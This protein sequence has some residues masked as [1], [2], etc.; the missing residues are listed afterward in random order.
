MPPLQPPHSPPP[1]PPTEPQQPQ[2]DP[3]L[4]PA[5]LPED[6]NHLKRVCEKWNAINLESCDGCEREW[7][8]LNV[9]PTG[10]GGNLCKDC[11]K[12]SPLFYKNNNM[13]PGPGCPD[14][15]SL[16][17]MEEILISPIRAL[18][19]VVNTVVIAVILFMKTKTSNNTFH[20][21]HMNAV[22]SS[23]AEGELLIQMTQQHL[24]TSVYA[25][26]IYSN[27]WLT[28][29]NTTQLSATQI[30]KLIMK[31][32]NNSLRMS[33]F[34][35]NS[36]I[37]QPQRLILRRTKALLRIV[38]VSLL[39]TSTPVVLSLTSMLEHMKLISFKMLHMLHQMFKSS[40]CLLCVV[41]HFLNMDQILQS[42]HS[43]HCFQ[44]AEVVLMSQDSVRYLKRIGQ[45]TSSSFVVDGLQDTHA[46]NTGPSIPFY[47]MKQRKP[48]HGTRQSSRARLPS[49]QHR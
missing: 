29:E 12:P 2:V 46:S 1:P 27:G 36:L 48:Q 22:L 21:F 38:M 28:S 16:T 17:Q 5:I 41:L 4:D 18:I 13:Y 14:L 32:Y 7:F 43:Q 33:W 34:T 6:C 20:F 49:Q 3:L 37:S 31:G 19:Q 11:Q 35:A 25:G 9:I 42:V 24:K 39:Q 8:D 10:S 40:P 23:S 44:L 26:V 30:S 15:P 47:N 45:T